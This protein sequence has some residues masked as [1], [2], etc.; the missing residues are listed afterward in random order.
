MFVFTIL[1]IIIAHAENIYGEQQSQCTGVA[2]LSY[3]S[4]CSLYYPQYG[5]DHPFTHCVHEYIACCCAHCLECHDC[6]EEPTEAPTSS[7]TEAT[8]EPTLAPSEPTLVTLEPTLA[9]TFSPTDEPTLPTLEPTS[10]PT[11]S[12][13]EVTAEPTLAT[14]EPILITLEPTFPTSEPTSPSVEPTTT[15]QPP[16]SGP[17]YASQLI[18]LEPTFPTVEPTS[19]SVEPTTTTQHPASGP[20][21]TTLITSGPTPMESTMVIS[22]SPSMEPTLGATLAESQP[23]DLTPQPTVQHSVSGSA[24]T[25]TETT[26]FSV[27]VELMLTVIFIG[28]W[29]LCCWGCYR[30]SKNKKQES[31]QYYPHIKDLEAIAEPY[32]TEDFIS[33]GYADVAVAAAESVS[34]IEM[35]YLAVQVSP[36]CTP[37]SP[38]GTERCTPGEGTTSTPGERCAARSGSTHSASAVDQSADPT[39]PDRS[40]AA[41]TETLASVGPMESISAEEDTSMSFYQDV[42]TE[43]AQRR[44]GDKRYT[45]SSIPEI[46]DEGNVT[47]FNAMDMMRKNAVKSSLNSELSFTA[48]MFQ[49]E[50]SVL[51][52]VVEVFYDDQ[53][54]NGF[55]VPLAEDSFSVEESLADFS[56]GGVN[57]Y[58]H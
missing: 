20:T 15:A 46:P 23:E 13:T 34:C 35:N 42:L 11:P 47:G 4:P 58:S 55:A 27:S 50:D 43:G 56:N 1:S 30:F 24:V 53:G 7:P 22:S 57:V 41:T 29:L 2:D 32:A 16:T 52:P 19:P 3:Y 44:T 51:P 8:V 37:G 39:A 33:E 31:A 21:F 45:T 26:H 17:T 10:S 54:S 18:T 9:P 48:D 14:P 6:T 38:M 28:S 49:V 36:E 25:T 12:P 40:R 5:P